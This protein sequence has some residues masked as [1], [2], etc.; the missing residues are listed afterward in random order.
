[1]HQVAVNPEVK[2]IVSGIGIHGGFHAIPG[3]WIKLGSAVP[4]I[5]GGCDIVT[6]DFV[7]AKYAFYLAHAHFVIGIGCFFDAHN[8]LVIISRFIAELLAQVNVSAHVQTLDAG[9]Q[10]AHNF[11]QTAFKVNGFRA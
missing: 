7:G 4:L 8:M 2:L 1:M 10:G 9:G 11:A 3:V 6:G 5:H